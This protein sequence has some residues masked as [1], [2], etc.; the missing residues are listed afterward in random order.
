MNFSNSK[1]EPLEDDDENQEGMEVDSP[2]TFK[3][4]R[5]PTGGQRSLDTKVMKESKK[6]HIEGTG[7]DQRQQTQVRR[8]TE[9]V[10]I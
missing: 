10:K 7:S 9:F 6:N 8:S 5:S 4:R 2:E 1:T 3:R